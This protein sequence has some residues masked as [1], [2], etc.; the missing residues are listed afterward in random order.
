MDHKPPYHCE[1]AKLTSVYA[2]T[3]NRTSLYVC[4]SYVELLETA[5]EVL[6][7]K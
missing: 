2:Q 3:I 7:Q 4:M 1:I 5:S 6:K